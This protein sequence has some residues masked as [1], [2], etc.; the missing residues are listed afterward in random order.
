M[1]SSRRSEDIAAGI[2]VSAES[3]RRMFPP[4]F[5]KSSSSFGVNEGP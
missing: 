4:A 2:G 5:V 3:A 1:S